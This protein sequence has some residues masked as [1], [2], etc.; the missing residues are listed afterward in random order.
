MK[1]TDKAATNYRIGQSKL[2][3][4]LL[5]ALLLCCFVFPNF[6]KAQDEEDNTPVKIDTL[7][8][9]IP[10]TVSDKKGIYVAGLK[11]ENFTIYE[12]GLSQNIELFLNEEAPMNVAIL[13]DTSYSTKD[14]L[15]NIQKA[16]RDFV[17][18][19]RPGDK[20]VIVSFDNR[21][22][23]LTKL[24]SDRK[25]LSTA[26]ERVSVSNVNG[27]DMYEAI[28][29]VAK[30][31]FSALKGRKA[32]IALTDG[33]V[34][35]RG[36]SAQQ[37]LDTL[38]RSDTFFYP[39]IFQTGALKN[40]RK[41]VTV[42]LLQIM[43]EDTGGKFYEKDSTKLKEAFQSI[44]EDLKNQYLLG[45]YPRNTETASL[46]SRIRVTVDRTDLVVRTK[47]RLGL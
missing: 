3:S 6:L 16:A 11:K 33:M 23:F 32:I 34:T 43:A 45:F 15:D 4:K 21:T 7:L 47:K 12:D 37:I 46:R 44:A 20:A 17:K 26:I 22:V 9:T 14:V 35:G 36:I 2:I 28:T 8:F 27:S 25:V 18:I 5:I 29:E 30:N 42:E 39:I 1:E 13:L 10:L 19:L 41:P 40:K 31:Y 38:H 24:E